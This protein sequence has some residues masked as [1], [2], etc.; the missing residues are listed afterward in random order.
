MWTWRHATFGTQKKGRKRAEKSKRGSERR[1]F[2]FLP[3]FCVPNVST[4]GGKERW[5]PEQIDQLQQQKGRPLKI[6]GGTA[7]TGKPHVGY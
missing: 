1:S 2:F 3:F 5:I 6:Y 4:K 7:T